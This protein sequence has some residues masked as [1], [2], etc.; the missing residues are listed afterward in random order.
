MATATVTVRLDA[1]DKAAMERACKE[2]GLSMNT[3]FTIFAKK[4]AR[5][6]RI[7]FVLEVDGFNS[8]PNLAH[9]DRYRG[10]GGWAWHLARVDRG[11]VTSSG[12]PRP[13]RIICGGK[14]RIERLSS[15]LTHYYV[16]LPGTGKMLEL[17]RRNR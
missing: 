7:P 16:T 12:P 10:A 2:M 6:Q 8:R 15:A 1:E 13:G 5:E 11:C 14:P 9:L 3:A 4:V 17:V